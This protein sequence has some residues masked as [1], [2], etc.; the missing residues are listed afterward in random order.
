[1]VLCKLIVDIDNNVSIQ[2]IQLAQE[3]S[4]WKRRLLDSS[5]CFEFANE[6]KAQ[7]MCS[8]HRL[9][10]L[11]KLIIKLLVKMCSVHRLILLN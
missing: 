4:G 3:N 5:Y 11:N 10:L 7:K 1:M 9:I 2:N 8:V 6:H